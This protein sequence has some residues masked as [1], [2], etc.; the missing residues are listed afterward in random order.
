MPS[1]DLPCA[2][3]GARPEEKRL[4]H[5]SA[6]TPGSLVDRLAREAAQ[7]RSVSGSYRHRRP[8]DWKGGPA[9]VIRHLDKVCG[10]NPKSLA[11][12][13]VHRSHLRSLG[14]G[15]G[16]E[17]STSPL[18]G[19]VW[20]SVKIGAPSFSEGCFM[21]VAILVVPYKYWRIRVLADS[22]RGQH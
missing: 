22:F 2:H 10:D 1:R 5:G 20:V 12:S 15:G 11:A 19:L 8:S 6:P 9:P 16:S 4:A 14:A 18:V 3:G 21:Y 7:R 13:L 17:L